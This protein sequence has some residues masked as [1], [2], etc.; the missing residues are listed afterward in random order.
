MSAPP[1]RILLVED[2]ETIRHAFGILLEESG[3][4][5]VQAANG[6]DALA[7]ARA[8]APDLVLMDLGLP[9]L[10]GLEVTRR[11]KGDPATRNI[12]VVALT[13]RALETDAAASL[14]AGCDGYLSKPIDS[15]QLLRR[16]P[17][18]LMGS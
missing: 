16:I 14:A 17:E 12:V 2:N 6:A 1:R 7:R 5:V 8:D 11:I 10:N 9:D 15:E 18:F 4:E 3:Y 13:G